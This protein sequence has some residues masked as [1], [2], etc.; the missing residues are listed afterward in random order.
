M[1]AGDPRAKLAALQAVCEALAHPARRQILLTVHFRE[2]MSA[3]QI[4]GRFAHAW[5][6]TTRHL[7]V[8]E[9]AGLLAHER[10]GRARVYRVARE[11]LALLGEWLAW[12]DRAG[13]VVA[14][15][16]EPPAAA[17]AKRR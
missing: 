13:G 3:G 12:F 2:Q 17:R 9:N 10:Q 1:T 5:P 8:L 11:P 14:E 7:R 6:T 15:A 4:A 16:D